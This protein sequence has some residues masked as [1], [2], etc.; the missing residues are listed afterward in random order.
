MVK[1]KPSCLKY[2]ADQT[3][4]PPYQLTEDGIFQMTT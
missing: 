2:K 1:K 4:T 3:I